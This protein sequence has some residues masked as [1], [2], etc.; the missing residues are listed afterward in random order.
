MPVEAVPTPLDPARAHLD[1][2]FRFSDFRVSGSGFQVEI[3]TLCDPAYAY[4]VAGFGLWVSRFRIFGL[5]VSGTLK[6][7]RS[8]KPKHV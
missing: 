7:V 3:F 4:L 8:R 6:Q 5:Q 1:S 2:D